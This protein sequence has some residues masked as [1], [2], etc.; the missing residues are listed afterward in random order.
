VLGTPA[1]MAPEQ[2]R[3]DRHLD[4]RADVF[5]L[6]CVLFECLTGRKP[7]EGMHPLA[8]LAKILFEEA[9]RVRELLSDVPPAVDALVARML[10]KDIA[11]RPADGARVAV[12]MASIM[13]LG[14]TSWPSG[15]PLAPAP[16]G[17]EQGM[18]S[19]IL[20]GVDPAS[21]RV[22]ADEPERSSGPE[23]PL[24]AAALR[25]SARIEHLADGS[26]I[27]VLGGQGSAT[28]LAGQAARCALSMRGALPAAPM[29]LATGSGVVRGR[30]P[31]GAAIDRAVALLQIAPPPSQSHRPVAGAELRATPPSARRRIA[32]IHLDD[33]TAGLLDARFDVAEDLGAYKLLGEREA[34]DGAVRTLLG[35]PTPCVGRDRELST[36][37]ATFEECV[38]ESVAHAVL[39][40]GA[41]GIGKSRVRHE[42]LR[43]L[44]GLGA[45]V[46][47]RIS[48]TDLGWAL[49]RAAVRTLDPGP[50]TRPPVEIWIARGDP[51]SAGSPL[52]LLAQLLRRAAGILD[53]QPL[54]VR[55]EKLRARVDL[56]VSAALAP[57]VAEFLGELTGTP[58]PD[59]DSVELRAAR[60]D[61][62]LMG[63]QMRK[64][65]EDFVEAECAAHPL[66]IVLE[67]LHWGDLPS[68]QFIDAILRRLR[69]RPL[70][71]V[72]VGRPEVHELFPRLWADHRMREIRLGELPRRAGE[73]LLRQFLGERA[74]PELTEQLLNQSEGNA[75][76]LEELIRA[77]ADGRGEAPP[78]PVLSM[79]QARFATFPSEAR[80]VL[81]AASVFGQVF[82]GGGVLLLLGEGASV[83]PEWLEG[84]LRREAI[85]ARREGKFPGQ[86]EYVFH[87]AWVRDAAYAT[88]TEADQRLGHRLAAGWLEAA[89][90]SDAATLAEHRARGGEPARAAS[91][92]LR[93]AEQAL[94]GND[95]EASIGYAKRGVA[96]GALGE[97]KGALLL[98]QA[99]ANRYMG[100]NVEADACSIEAMRLLSRGS[101]KWFHAV[102][103]LGFASGKIGKY[104]RLI[105]LS[106]ELFRI[107][108]RGEPGP[109]VLAAARVALQLFMA[110]Q[111]ELGDRLLATAEAAAA[112]AQV[113]DPV[114]VAFVERSRAIR[115]MLAGDLS[116]F[117]AFMTEAAVS[118]ERAGAQRSALG[119]RANVAQACLTLGA[120]AEAEAVLRDV[121]DRASRMGLFEL[122][123]SVRH[124]LALSV[125]R[126]GGLDEA[127]AMVTAARDAAIAQRSPRLEGLCRTYRSII[128]LLARD[129]SGAEREAQAATDIPDLAPPLR[130]YPLGTLSRALLAEGRASLALSASEKAMA[131]MHSPAG[132][133]D[134]EFPVHLAHIEALL[135]NELPKAA[136]EAITVA[137]DRLLQRAAR[138]SDPTFR[139]RFLSAVP[140][141][142]RILELARL[143]LRPA[144][145]RR[146][147]YPPGASSPGSSRSG[148]PSSRPPKT[149]PSRSSPSPLPPYP[150]K[151]TQPPQPALPAK[152]TPPPPSSRR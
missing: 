91:L 16:T 121:L 147:S 39:L 146:G 45:R 110:G 87:H 68:V 151:G 144:P 44:R 7:F 134:G 152:T 142:T 61:A 70:L 120:Y 112:H 95:L 76:H 5:A 12:E 53:G 140:D 106:Q 71:I 23:E 37:D 35:R 77:V 65:W 75:F 107:E 109:Y 10:Y 145:V 130:A 20:A 6:G 132:I 63:D 54:P 28:F 47:D 11:G 125:A 135:A 88:L 40:T 1:Y 141:N 116:A 21:V 126:Q 108:V 8:V 136:E 122:A 78:K 60:R 114:M 92:Y 143:W 58:F 56:S 15:S 52:G 25:F 3:G 74:T 41:A 46:D 148:S 113:P 149:Q 127:L 150:S 36:L 115:S 57:R 119:Q 93:T 79:V 14:R 64:A 81:R 4:A 86:D 139:E 29:V 2:A 117:V 27:A 97:V 104:D 99:E 131:L 13:T 19:V 32:P 103:E 94:Q 89:G 17:A 55:Q 83:A 43:N 30:L 105:P 124:T 31:I 51:L 129:A 26:S 118:F 33:V 59:D 73:R 42:F 72:A 123:A 50:P 100:R 80:R 111:G 84:L 90:E 38:A 98:V 138:I 18:V 96:C 66:L 128:L 24:L 9:P 101:S 49:D 69:A 85:V 22:A 62:M 67:D 137:R 133:E 102:G 48:A 34:L 82:W